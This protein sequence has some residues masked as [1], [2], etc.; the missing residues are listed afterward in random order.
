MEPLQLGAVYN[1]V[2]KKCGG[3]GHIASE[4]FN[5]SG[6]GYLLVEEEEDHRTIK[7]RDNG[8]GGGGGGGGE[9]KKYQAINPYASNQDNHY[10]NINAYLYLLHLH[11]H[12][13]Q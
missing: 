3:K 2:C 11:L 7:G 13:H 10:D 5:T 9:D 6:Q 12:Y 8:G 1:T 4:C